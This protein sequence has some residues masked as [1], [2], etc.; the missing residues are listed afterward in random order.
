MS[1]NLLD[2]AL[3]KAIQ[4]SRNETGLWLACQLRDSGYTEGEAE[5]IS[6][7]SSL[8]GVMS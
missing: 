3:R 4:G 7:I 6:P 2:K 1:S 5:S 8:K